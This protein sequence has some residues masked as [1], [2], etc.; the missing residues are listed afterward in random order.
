MNKKI[1]LGLIVPFK[2]IKKVIISYKFTLN[3]LSKYFEN[4]YVI[5]SE[6]LEFFPETYKSYENTDLYDQ[7]NKNIN[8]INTSLIDMSPKFPTIHLN[9]NLT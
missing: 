3:E 1:H 5:N 8:L 7:L 6:Y 9:S 4:I 2:G